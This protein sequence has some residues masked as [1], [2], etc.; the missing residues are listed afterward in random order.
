VQGQ[1]ELVEKP[2]ESNRE[3]AASDRFESGDFKGENSREYDIL[4]ID[5]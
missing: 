3:F 2:A 4:D 1:G 5:P